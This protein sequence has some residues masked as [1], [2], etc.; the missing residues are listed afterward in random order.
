MKDKLIDRK[1]SRLSKV[2][3]DKYELFNKTIP[4]STTGLF[5][6]ASIETS[7]SNIPGS[8]P[9]IEDIPTT[10]TTTTTSTTTTTTTVVPTT[11]TTST[12]T[13][14]TTTSIIPPGAVPVPVLI[15][16]ET[17]SPVEDIVVSNTLEDMCIFAN[18]A[19]NNNITP[20]SAIIDQTTYY[21]DPETDILYNSVTNTFAEDGY[22]LSEGIFQ[23]IDGLI[24]VIDDPFELCG[25]TTTTTTT[26]STTSTTTT[27]TSTTSTTTTT[28]TLPPTNFISTWR[29]TTAS[30]SITLPY[31]NTGTYTGTIDWGDG[32]TSDNSYA[33][34][35]HTYTTAGDYI[36]TVFGLINN[37][38]FGINSNT[39]NAAKL[40]SIAEWGGSFRLGNAGSYFYYCTNLDLSGVTDVLN[41]SGTTNLNSMFYN[42][43]LLTTVGRMNE[44]DV[45]A[46][47]NMEIIFSRT[48]FFN[49]NIGSWNVSNVTNMR[50][51]FGNA[52]AFNQNIGSWNVGN[53][54]NM[55]GMFENAY[56]FNQ[57]LSTWCVSL[58]P[59]QP[60]GFATG[61]TAWVLPK[62]VWGTCP[63]TTTSTTT[64]TTTV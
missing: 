11:T 24:Q 58:I 43:S 12:T 62:P 19:I 32:T 10:T 54:T 20:G 25:I 6:E 36:V 60:F 15:G 61:A 50:Q 28:T 3:S 33:N 59:T 35:A 18:N 64:S 39:T 42:C 31:S 40:R 47:T 52:Y 38:S 55:N 30:E 21:F 27:T 49:Q 13:T 23:V 34:R 16:Y 5:Y 9:S 8:T 22:Y 1:T 2:N 48:N 57:N 46:V 53:V 63:T 7:R 29:T 51:M 26:T 37:F 45:S 44:W 4:S 17:I 56:A 14:T 41:L